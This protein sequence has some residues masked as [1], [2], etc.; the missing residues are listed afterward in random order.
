MLFINISLP[1]LR[2]DHVFLD[3]METI[4]DSKKGSLTFAPEAG[5][6]RMRDV[7]NKGI[8]TEDIMQG[9]AICF[10]AQHF[11][12][13]PN[14]P[15]FPSVVLKPHQKYKQKTVYKFGVEK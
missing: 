4:Q 1:S 5:S 12:D 9:S 2:I 10:E 3:M 8:T 13:S 14:H 6:Q 15:Y 7:I 11:P